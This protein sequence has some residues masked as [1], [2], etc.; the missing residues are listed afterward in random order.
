MTSDRALRPADAR[1][2]ASPCRGDGRP[3]APRRAVAREDAPLTAS[4][5][6]GGVATDGVRAVGGAA[7][8]CALGCGAAVRAVRSGTAVGRGAVGEPQRLGGDV[9]GAHGGDP[10]GAQDV[11]LALGLVAPVVLGDDGAAGPGLV[12]VPGGEAGKVGDAVGPADGEGVPAVAPGT[13]R[14]VLGVEDEKVLADDGA[15]PHELAG[16]GETRLAGTDDDD[17]EGDLRGLAGDGALGRVSSAH[18]AMQPR[19]PGGRRQPGAMRRLPPPSS[20]PSARVSPF[21]ARP[22]AQGADSRRTG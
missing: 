20:T 18:R 6:S 3:G 17:A 4:P 11:Q 16:R 14:A 12:H 21:G 8:G 5:T 13:A 2:A 1:T 19:V 15:A 22:P 9:G 10:H 7:R